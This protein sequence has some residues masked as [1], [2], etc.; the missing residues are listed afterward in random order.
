M[1]SQNLSDT[2]IVL[3]DLWKEKKQLRRTAEQLALYLIDHKDDNRYG[4]VDFSNFY[5][6]EIPNNNFRWLYW[7]IDLLYNTEFY[8]RSKG[9]SL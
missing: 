3:D 1:T 4:L 6:N 5:M 9:F 8:N 7:Y 2:K